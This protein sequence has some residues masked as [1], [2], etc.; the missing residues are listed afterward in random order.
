MSRQAAYLLFA[1]KCVVVTIFFTGSAAAQ[2]QDYPS[3]PIRIVVP[4][5]SGAPIEIVT[6]WIA[7]GMG[8]D[9]GQPIIIESRP[10]ALGAI[11]LREVLRANPDGYSVAVISMPM[12]V[13]PSISPAFQIDL[14][15]DF[16][17]VGQTVLSYNALVV[18]PTLPVTSIS[19][20][21]ALAKSKPGNLSFMSGGYGTPAHVIGELFKLETGIEVVHVPHAK[22][23]QGIGDVMTGRL[24]YGFLT[25]APTI[26]H[27][28][29][30]KL[31][32]IAVTAPKRLAALGNVPTVI[33]AGFPNL[34]VSDWGML[35]VRT[36]T[37]QAVIDRLNASMR[38][39][40]S[41]P[42]A[43]DALAKFGAEPNPSTPEAARLFLDSEIGRWAKV[44]RT[45]KLKIE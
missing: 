40:L 24:D 21:V 4:A 20:L 26:P 41:A 32:A 34:Q 30:G 9:L 42:T 5:G 22:F 29:A 23:L 6:R 28:A 16:Q 7:E 17:P 31:R 12:A 43:T 27:I 3:K 38:K 8:Q 18:T 37:P 11:G 39:A 35:L 1:L 44:A 25:T 13:A 15:K 2:G 19:E 36:G 45:G 14:T 10:G 33:E